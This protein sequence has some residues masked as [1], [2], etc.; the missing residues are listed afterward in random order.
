[1]ERRRWQKSVELESLLSQ[2]N[3]EEK[4]VIEY[5]LQNVSVGEICA[6]RELQVLEG[7]KDPARVI[8]ELIKKGLLERGA[9]CYNLSRRLREL[10]MQA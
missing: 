10:I 3:P 9:G 6:V 1:M 5:F 2:L 7:I 8:Y 4:R